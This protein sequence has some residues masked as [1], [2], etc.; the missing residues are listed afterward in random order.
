MPAPSANATK[1]SFEGS[2]LALMPP[3]TEKSLI[4]A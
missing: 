2:L 1:G 4:K 3:R